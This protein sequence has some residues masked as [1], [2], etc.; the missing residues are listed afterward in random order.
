MLDT[1]KKEKFSRKTIYLLAQME[2]MSVDVLSNFYSIAGFTPGIRSWLS[3][4]SKFALSLGV[5]FIVSGII[6]FFAYNWHDLHRFAKLA[7]VSFLLISSAAITLFSD[8]QKL[9]AK[10]SLVAAAFFT[11]CLLAVFGQ[12]YQTGANAYDLFLNWAILITGIVLISN[13]K[14]L[15]FLW[16]VLINTSIVLFAGQLLRN[17]INP[18]AII[19]LS[20]VNATALYIYE[21]SFLKKKILFESRWLPRILGFAVVT[22][23]TIAGITGILSDFDKSGYLI[24]LL[25]SFISYAGIIFFYSRKIYDLSTIAASFACISAVIFSAFKKAIRYDAAVIF[26]IGGFLIIGL[27]VSSV[28]IL[29]HINESWKRKIYEKP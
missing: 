25:L 16:L 1:I 9:H 11:G 5:L 28:F 15:W 27:T 18:Y 7:I 12:I 20:V 14:P 23:L 26:I 2:R 24:C 6:F 8:L 10:L 21:Y 29:M 17:W 19:S 13:F 4:F 22:S 3:F